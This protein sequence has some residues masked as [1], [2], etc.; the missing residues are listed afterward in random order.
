MLHSSLVHIFLFIYQKVT[1]V[2]LHFSA[3]I[4]SGILYLV[5]PMLFFQ[6]YEGWTYSQGLYYCFITLSTVGFGDFVASKVLKSTPT[7]TNYGNTTPKSS[8]TYVL[9]LIVSFLPCLAFQIMTL[10]RITLS[11]TDPSWEFGYFLAWPGWLYW[12]ITLLTFWGT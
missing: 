7:Y 4:G 9:T 1:L 12:S 2:L 6:V 5:I 10:T 11:G 8:F 3:F